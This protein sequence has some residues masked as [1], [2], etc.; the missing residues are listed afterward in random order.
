MNPVIAE[1]SSLVKLRVEFDPLRWRSLVG[2]GAVDV[3]TGNVRF[4]IERPEQTDDA[5]D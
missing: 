3:V 4:L 1:R 2:F 5:S